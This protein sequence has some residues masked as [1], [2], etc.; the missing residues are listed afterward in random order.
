MAQERPISAA[1]GWARDRKAERHGSRA[2]T[3]GAP[4]P[5]RTVQEGGLQDVVWGTK[6]QQ[7]GRAAEK[8]NAEGKGDRDCSWLGGVANRGGGGASA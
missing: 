4:A 2:R 7:K 3:P 8:R 5:L 1:E 6:R